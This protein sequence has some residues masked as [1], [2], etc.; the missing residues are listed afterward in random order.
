M[1]AVDTAGRSKVEENA[2][3]IQSSTAIA[4]VSCSAASRP[5]AVLVVGDAGEAGLADYMRREAADGEIL[6]LD[7]ALDPVVDALNTALKI[8]GDQ[9]QKASALFVDSVKNAIRAHLAHAARPDAGLEAPRAQRLSAWQERRAKAFLTQNASEDVS[10]AGAAAAC[11]LSR[12]YFIRAF[13]NTTGETPHRWLNRHRV[14][15]AKQLLLGDMP[16][17]QI[18]TDCGFS[19]QSHLTRVFAKAAGLPP[20]TWRRQYRDVIDGNRPPERIETAARR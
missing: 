19:D 18:A 17:A 6:A 8:A 15:R 10:I 3:E 1:S 14:E 9:Q 11:K 12:N 20:G 5:R 16:I 7:A 13:R 4:A 2:M